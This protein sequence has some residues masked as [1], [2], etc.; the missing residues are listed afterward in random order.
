MAHPTSVRLFGRPSKGCCPW[1]S[2]SRACADCRRCVRT[3]QTLEGPRCLACR[4]ASSFAGLAQLSVAHAGS[5]PRTRCA[6]AARSKEGTGRH[7]VKTR[8]GETVGSS[9]RQAAVRRHGQGVDERHQARHVRRRDRHAGRWREKRRSRCTSS[10]RCAARR[11]PS[12]VGPQAAIDHDQRQRRHDRHRRRQP[13]ADHEVQG[14]RKSSWSRRRRS[15]SPT[16]RAMSAEV[17]P[18]TGIFISAAQ[19][20]ADGSLK[21]PAHHLR[22]DGLMPP[23]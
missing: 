9:R 18:G 13:H 19:K 14:R 10:R 21:D 11:G 4:A 8:D 2:Q 23:M 20:Q 22:Q 5:L 16:R 3:R 17:G 12:A 7:I 1:Q 15:S 6:C